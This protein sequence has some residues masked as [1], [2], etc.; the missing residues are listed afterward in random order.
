MTAPKSSSSRWLPRFVSLI[1]LL[2][3]G[4]GL[5]YSF[6]PKPVPVDMAEAVEGDL[7][8]TIQEDGTTR[9][10]ER[11]TV[12]SPLAGRLLRIQLDPGDSVIGGET[13][14][15]IIE[16]SDPSLLDARAIAET[17]ARVDAAQARFEQ[18][19]TEI[20]RTKADYE[21]TLKEYDRIEGLRAKRA[22]TQADLDRAETQLKNASQNK[23][24]AEFAQKIA[25]FELKMAE[26]ALKR[27]N[28]EYDATL[29]NSNQFPMISPVT[30]RVLRVFQKSS[31]VVAPGE[32]L[33]ELGDPS[34][35]EVVVD[36]LSG[37]AVKIAPGNRVILDHW[38]G[39]DP[40][41]G[42]VRLVEPSGFT[43]ISA[44][45]V[46]EQRVNVVID[47]ESPFEKR[48]SLGDGFRV[49]AEIVVEERQNVLKIPTSALFR[50]QK[51]WAV[52]KVEE[53]KAS[54]QH[55]KLGSRNGLEAEVREGLRTGES[56]ILHPGSSVQS[57][58]LV[59][60]R[61]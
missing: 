22:A 53:N 34:D 38:G 59:E 1:L 56:V 4:Y 9:I 18:S 27:T 54:L 43:K 31:R 40:L 17:K 10:K 39:L 26:A 47:F 61:E 55:V 37:D 24:S 14:L 16:P 50:D 58:S 44:L 6:S 29:E 30:G 12:A 49:E 20:E 32:N 45:G 42:S 25:E 52:F 23:I 60:V 35:L 36:V 15:A 51:Q 3:V 28:P 2:L 19:Q 57:G 46:E 33:V 41:I 5:F 11:Y 21:L 13:L 48:K 8:V 7:L